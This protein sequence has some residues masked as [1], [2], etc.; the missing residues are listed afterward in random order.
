[1]SEEYK[2][3]NP[4]TYARIKKISGHHFALFVAENRIVDAN[5]L[6][7]RKS[8]A[9]AHIKTLN[10]VDLKHFI[11][12]WI[13][14]VHYRKE[15]YKNRPQEIKLLNELQYIKEIHTSNKEVFIDNQSEEL[16]LKL[17]PKVDKTDFGMSLLYQVFLKHFKIIATKEVYI[18]YLI[19]N[20][21]VSSVGSIRSED[22]VT[23]SSKNHT[24]FSSFEKE[25][26]KLE[27]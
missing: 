1:M 10:K 18:E 15:R 8:Y 13:R 14:Y 19:L 12:G 24:L 11:G 23:R 25:I 22:E 7:M 17:L 27:N 20:N 3:T 4:K 16:F 5:N 6:N 26:S 2:G 9:D 21:I